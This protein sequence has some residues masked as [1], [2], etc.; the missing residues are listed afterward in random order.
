[1]KTG[2]FFLCLLIASASYAAE[3][4][5]AFGFVSLARLR[6]REAPA[7]QRA[8]AGDVIA[9]THMLVSAGKYSLLGFAHTQAEADEATAY[10]TGVLKAAGIATVAATFD[11]G[12]YQI[13]YKTDDGRV[14]RDFV[15]D[16]LQFP[17]KDAAGLRADMALTAGALKKSGHDVVA[18]R[19]L[20]LDIILPTYSVLYLTRPD[21][22]P[23]HEARLRILKAGFDIEFDI[24]RGAGV[25]VVSTPKTWIMVYIGPEVGQVSMVAKTQEEIDAKVVARRE[26]L[27]GQ[28]KR[29]IAE[30]REPIDDA[31]YKFGAALYF[32]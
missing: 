20:D 26:F 6:E 14:I 22:I 4:L 30:R 2:L 8:Q 28:G 9:S 11:G 12:M 7:A 5:P 1:M 27:L 32:Q 18:A 25:D 13:F 3:G 31:E 17:P 16:P 15:A 23:E 24:F 29:I 10:W 21:E 19:V